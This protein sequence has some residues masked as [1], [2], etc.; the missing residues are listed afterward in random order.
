M[1]KHAGELGISTGER[2]LKRILF[3]WDSTIG[4]RPMQEES[5]KRNALQNRG[6]AYIRGEP[7]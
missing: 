6:Q 1:Q 7:D 4:A 2:R 5:A 3:L